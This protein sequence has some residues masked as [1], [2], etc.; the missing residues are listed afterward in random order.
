M[1]FLNK[2][3][4]I[5]FVDERPEAEAGADLQ[6]QGRDR[7]LRPPSQRLQRGALPQGLLVRAEGGRPWRWRSPCSGTPGSTRA[8]IRSPTGY[9]P[10]TAGCTRRASRSPS[11]TWPT[12]TRGPRE[13]L[14]EKDDNLLGEDIRE[15]LTA[16]ISVRL[17]GPPVRG[18]DQGQAG[19]RPGP[20]AGGAGD[21]R[22]AD[23]LVRG[24]PTR[25]RPDHPEGP[26]R[27]PGP[28]GGTLRP[29]PH[30]AQ[31]GA[32]RGGP[33]GQVGRLLVAG[34]ARERIVHRRGQLGR[35]LGQGRRAIP[36]PRPSCP[37]GAR[38]STSSGPASTR[39]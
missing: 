7:R 22:E 21:Q 37:S 19:E 30:P 12:S 15:G 35:R 5:R 13:R 27:R 16:I 36:R 18:S 1:A 31:V 32:R 2:G 9:P 24:E 29:R 11:P 34:P 26:A 33:A 10:S 14:K 6:V 39:C 3:L 38:S 20:F 28:G 17:A 8:S 23:R 4:E 25:G